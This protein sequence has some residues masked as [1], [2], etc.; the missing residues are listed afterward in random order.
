MSARIVVLLCQVDRSTQSC[1]HIGM[2]TTN[3]VA[4]LNKLYT[5]G[6]SRQTLR[7][8]AKRQAGLC[9]DCNAKVKP[10][11]S[12]AGKVHTPCRCP[13]CASKH[14]VYVANKDRGKPG[15]VMVVND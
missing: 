4:I 2:D 6:I 12:K 14:A 15:Q 13:A 10:I 5:V 8:R 7:L 11:K 3:A 1:Y 9:H